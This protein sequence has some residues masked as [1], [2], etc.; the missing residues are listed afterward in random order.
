LCKL[1]SLP[2]AGEARVLA[3]PLFQI[4]DNENSGGRG[5]FP[6]FRKILQ[7]HGKQQAG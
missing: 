7:K 1:T 2:A 6:I 5:A 4:C 3:A